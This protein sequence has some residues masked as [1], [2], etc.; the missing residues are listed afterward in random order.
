MSYVPA[1]TPAMPTHVTA[2]IHDA[3]T[4]FREHVVELLEEADALIGYGWATDL[5]KMRDDLVLT[6][7]LRNTR[8]NAPTYRGANAPAE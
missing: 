1:T 2:Q 6:A 7:V 8:V 3:F 4:A 5:E